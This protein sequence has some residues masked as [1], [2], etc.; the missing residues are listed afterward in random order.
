MKHVWRLR[1]LLLLL[2]SGRTPLATIEPSDDNSCSCYSCLWFFFPF[3]ALAAVS[4]LRLKPASVATFH[5]RSIPTY[6][7]FHAPLHHYALFVPGIEVFWRCFF[8][9]LEYHYSFICWMGGFSPSLS[10]YYLPRNPLTRPVVFCLPRSFF[11]TI[12][13]LLSC[14]LLLYPWKTFLPFFNCLF[15]ISIINADFSFVLFF[16]PYLSCSG[17]RFI[18][19]SFSFSVSNI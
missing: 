11:F 9:A 13:Y 18:V 5:A 6:D 12:T 1:S 15:Q 17:N 8:F 3:P 14:W 16:L 4:L 19:S 2:S 7:R 10:F